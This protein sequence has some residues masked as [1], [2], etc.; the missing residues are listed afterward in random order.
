MEH[1]STFHDNFIVIKQEWQDKKK[2]PINAANYKTFPINF[3]ASLSAVHFV[4]EI[5][6]K[7]NITSDTDPYN[8]LR[9]KQ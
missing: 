5:K 6:N 4:N 3:G 9:K 8:F 1:T 2:V 7:P